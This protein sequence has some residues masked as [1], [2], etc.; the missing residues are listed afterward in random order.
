[1]VSSRMSL[2]HGAGAAA[3]RRQSPQGGPRGRSAASATVNAAITEA[4]TEAIAAVVTAEQK[5]LRR[6][7]GRTVWAVWLEYVGR[8]GLAKA[9]WAQRTARAVRAVR[10]KGWKT[11]QKTGRTGLAEGPGV[12]GSIVIA[13]LVAVVAVVVTGK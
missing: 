3:P 10:T 4:I 1:M 2:P 5:G 11:G 13:A 6:A 9:V 12:G 8:T 7:A